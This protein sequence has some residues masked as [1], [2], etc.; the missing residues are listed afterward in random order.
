MRKRVADPGLVTLIRGWEL[1]AMSV[2]GLCVMQA[3]ACLSVFRKIWARTAML[4]ALLVLPVSV[5]AQVCA[6]PGKD[7]GERPAGW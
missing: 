6:A 2:F 7:G 3:L 1:S 5:W 4:V